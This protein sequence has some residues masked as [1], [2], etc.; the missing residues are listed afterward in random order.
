MNGTEEPESQTLAQKMSSM[1][2]GRQEEEI[3]KPCPEVNRHNHQGM[4]HEF[5]Y[6]PLPAPAQ[7]SQPEG[8]IA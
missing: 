5:P 3:T 6:L 8:P 1:K 4:G 2:A 7:S